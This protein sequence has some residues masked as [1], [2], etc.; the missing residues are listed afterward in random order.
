[1]AEDYTEDSPYTYCSNNP[2]LHI[3]IDGEFPLVTNVG[4]AAGS[5]IG[6]FGGNWF[7]T[8][9]INSLYGKKI[10]CSRENL[11]II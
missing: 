8:S 3:D 6:S 4:G 11:S 5:I 9:C 2:I 7:G 1:M 10:V